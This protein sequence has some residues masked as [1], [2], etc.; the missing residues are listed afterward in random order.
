M[1][2]LERPFVDDLAQALI[3]DTQPVVWPTVADL[4]YLIVYH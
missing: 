3:L 1:A 4:G 2:D